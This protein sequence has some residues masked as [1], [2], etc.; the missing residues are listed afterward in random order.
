MSR[1]VA[2]RLVSMVPLLIL[3]S[4][5]AFSLVLLL[6]GDP[7]LAILGE[8]LANANNGS[9]YYALR[10]E[11]GLD[12][13]IPVQYLAW[14]SRAIQG[15]FGTSIRNKTPIGQSMI[16]HIVPTLELAILGAILSILIAFPAGI[17]SALKPNSL[18][19]VAATFLALSGVAIPHFFLGILL[20]YTFAV[21]LGVLPPSGYVPPW[22]NLGENLK[23]MLMPAFAIGTGLAAVM[24][25]QVR[26]ALIEVLQQEYI[27]TARAKG[28]APWPVVIRHA[29]KNAAIPVVTIMGQ[30][31]GTLIGGAVVTETIFSIPGMGRMIVESI[32]FRDFPVVQASVL[33]LSVSVLLANLT[34]DIAYGFLDPRIRHD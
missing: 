4:M 28:L 20:I 13:P 2:R 32:F 25:R 1:F 24:M 7:A 27:M 31:V 23:L 12:D 9:A 21:Y 26:S 29:F 5:I 19:D 8:E 30:Q 11:M 33:I 18:A 3:I 16:T 15:D 6:P 10:E 22:E 34:T 17:I 14:A